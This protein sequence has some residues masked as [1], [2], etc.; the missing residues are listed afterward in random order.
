MTTDE[1]RSGLPIE[2]LLAV[3]AEARPDSP[4][5]RM[6]LERA[7]DLS[8]GTHRDDL[9][10]ALLRG[11]LSD[12]APDWMLKAA[13]DSGLK[14]EVRPYGGS[15][16]SLARVA[17]AHPSCP[18]SLREE[19]LR[20]CSVAQL[21][22]LGREGCGEALAAAVVAEL[23]ERCPR[24]QP[25]TPELLEEP[26]VPQLILREPHLH[27]AVFFAALGLLPEYPQ[28]PAEDESEED[29]DLTRFDRFWAARKA[30]E[31]MWENIVAVQTSR[32][33]QLIDWAPDSRSRTTIRDLLLGAIP[34]DVEPSLLEEMA[35][36]DLAGFAVSDLITRL[37]G[38]LRDG[39]PE[40]EIRSRI[41]VELDALK[42]EVRERTEDYFND[43][44]GIRKYGLRAAA[45]WVASRA[46]GSWRYI[47][48]PSEAKTSYGKAHDWLASEKLLATLGQR[49]AATAVKALHLW[50]PAPDTLR[51]SPRDLRW[52][53]AALLHL[54]HLTEDV[55]E[56]ARAVIRHVRPSSRN[57]WERLD[58]KTQQDDQRLT[59][60][61]TAIERILGDPAAV[62][63]SAA[64]G[65]TDQVT[66][67][68][69]ARASDE[70]LDDYLTRHAGNDALV[71]LAL[72]SFATSSYRSKPSFSEVLARHSSP[73]AALAQ[74]TTDLRKR[75]GG[76]PHLR[77]AWARQVLTLPDLTPELI[78]VLPAWTALTVGGP[79]YGTAHKAVASVVLAALGDSDEAW[80][81]FAA[82][83]ASYSGPTAWLRLGDVLD[84]A[85]KGSDWPTPPKS[86]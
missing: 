11:A 86:K 18:D 46:D 53:H 43:V 6:A 57:P 71:E 2:F 28:L 42:P 16:L 12:S 81:R 72:L 48:T 20:R 39:V 9:L 51:P 67:R 10:L 61:R 65:D 55:K 34:W 73:E 25:M 5:I 66:V 80:S 1:P 62:S 8:E 13:V 59:E 54:P 52:L 24:K 7:R 63:R 50:E 47:L 76:G 75:L 14:E 45:S 22:A 74:I 15:L 77:E 3:A 40:D 4:P 31:G 64:L 68:E 27:D 26:D 69:L 70:A 44:A 41:A 37:C 29:G 33:R 56:K 23:K 17:L 79:R 58:H 78:R 35:Y 19:A 30:W 84:A 38:M 82:S 32:H 85:A 83:P 36:E 60:L 21:G 49:F